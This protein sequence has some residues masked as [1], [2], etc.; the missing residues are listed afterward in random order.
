[1]NVNIQKPLKIIVVSSSSTQDFL[2]KL[3]QIHSS[4]QDK[5]TN[6]FVKLS[7]KVQRMILLASSKGIIIPQ[8]L[9]EEAA[10]FFEI[11]NFSKM[12]QF[13]ESYLEA[14]NVECVVPTAVANLWHQGCLLWAN[15][16][17][18]LGLSASVI[19]TKDVLFNDLLHQ[20][21]LLDFSTKYEITKN[22]LSR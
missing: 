18:P 3:T 2:S 4:S 22:S 16:L 1:M 12:Q 10:L 21:I 9:N 11:Q 13:L 8:E 20:G 17:T 7:E 19:A 14:R 15:S 6:S 5:S